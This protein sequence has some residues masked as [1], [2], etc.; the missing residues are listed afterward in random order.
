MVRSWTMVRSCTFH[1]RWGC[2]TPVF[3]A[4]E[5]RSPPVDTEP[6]T[7]MGAVWRRPPSGRLRIKCKR[8]RLLTTAGEGGLESMASVAQLLSPVTLPINT[9]EARSS[10]PS[11]SS[12]LGLD[13]LT[14]LMAERDGV[15]PYLS[16]FLKG[17]S[18]GNRVRSG[19]LWQ[20]ARL[21]RLSARFQLVC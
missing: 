18:T 8:L 5:L 3:S 9:N 21:R 17:V 20:L 11:R 12:I 15:G 10:A 14:F 19:S 4:S 7:L 16:A 6:Q 13:A 2:N 1:H